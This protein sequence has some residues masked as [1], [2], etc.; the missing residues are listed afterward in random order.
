[1]KDFQNWHWRITKL[2]IWKISTV[3]NEQFSLVSSLSCGVLHDAHLP[4]GGQQL[5]QPRLLPDGQLL[6]HLPHHQPALPAVGGAEGWDHCLGHGE[7]PG[8][9]PG[10][11]GAIAG[12]PGHLPALGAGVAVQEMMEGVGWGW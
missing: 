10:G 11:V 2:R 9:R 12:G 5:Q 7:G 1:M 8:H 4:C 3:C 6:L